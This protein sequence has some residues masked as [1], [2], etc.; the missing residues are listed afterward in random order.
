MASDHGSRKEGYVINLDSRVLEFIPRYVGSFSSAS[1]DRRYAGS[2]LFGYGSSVSKQYQT[3]VADKY[4]NIISAGLL[5]DDRPLTQFI[6][7]AREV[8]DFVKDTFE[9][10]T[11]KSFPADIVLWVCTEENLMKAHIANGGVW[12]PG[13]QGF[14]LNSRTGSRRIFVKKNNLDAL[15]LVIGHEIGHVL[16]EHLPDQLDEE[17]K[18]FAFEIAW[19]KTIIEHDIA[20]LKNCFNVNFTPAENGLHNIAFAF[21]QKITK[22]GKDAIDTYWELVRRTLRV[23]DF[24]AESI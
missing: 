6:D 20:G 13:I 11:G 16:T 21:V 22:R 4:N 2:R 15:M 1:R 19:V 12:N 17:A 7:D 23:K 18:A 14:A 5:K 10:L 24:Y 8:E 9:K 3:V